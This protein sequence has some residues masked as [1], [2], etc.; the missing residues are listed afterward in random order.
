M[1]NGNFIKT[2]PDYGDG[3]EPLPPEILLEHHLKDS[4]ISLTVS[5]MQGKMVT[6][7]KY[8]GSNL[9]FNF[10]IIPFGT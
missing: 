10:K 9:F 5:K 2:I 4:S 7:N 1:T 6:T 8:A 3:E